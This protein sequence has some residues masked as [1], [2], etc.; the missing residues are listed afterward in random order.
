MRDNINNT[1]IEELET[2]YN[3]DFGGMETEYKASLN[4]IS[5]PNDFL[6]DTNMI[7]VVRRFGSQAVMVY[8][9]LHAKMCKE[10]YKIV[11]N[12]IQQDI[13]KVTLAGIYKVDI[14]MID[15]IIS[16]FV[17]VKLLHIISDGKEQYLTSVYQVFIYERVSAK[18]LR[19]KISKRNSKVSKSA[20]KIKTETKLPVFKEESVDEKQTTCYDEMANMVNTEE[21]IPEGFT[22][23]NDIEI[24]FT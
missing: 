20:D 18:R 17:E 9:Y 14:N 21:S 3:P 10:G 24:P 4:D 8:V 5:L 13:I 6:E 15:E 2:V 23:M 16:A 7:S 19:D 12:D 22:E 11:W 1:I